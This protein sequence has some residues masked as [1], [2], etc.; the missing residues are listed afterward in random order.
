MTLRHAILGI[1]AQ[2]PSTGFDLLREF[3]ASQS[4]IW[5]APQNEVYRVLRQLKE[6]GLAEIVATGARGSRT[7][8]AT[9]AGLAELA[10][11]LSAPSDY[12]L[13][14][15]P[16]LKACFLDQTDP[17]SRIE[18]A[19]DD[20]AFFEEQLRIIE[21]T[22]REKAGQPGPVREDA[23]AMAVALYTALAGW[24]RTIVEEEKA[25]GAD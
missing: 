4:V 7:Y 20:L 17:S 19:R 8:A 18:R 24:A 16:V 12:T 21:R 15:E 11:W 9:D 6:E 3:D 13:R 14:Y 10:A 25:A 1:I 5:P 22:A 23:R 2:K